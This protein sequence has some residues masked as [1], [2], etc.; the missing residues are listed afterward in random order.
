[1][2]IKAKRV[3]FMLEGHVLDAQAMAPLVIPGLR[4]LGAVLEVPVVTLILQAR[5]LG[6]MVV[7]VVLAKLVAGRAVPEVPVMRVVR[8]VQGAPA[9][10][11][12]SL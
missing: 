4:I 6:A 1:V 2:A 10:L 8:A 9:L 7:V 5:H 3:L 11:H 12:V